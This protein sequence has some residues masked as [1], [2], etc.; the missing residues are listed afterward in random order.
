MEKPQLVVLRWSGFSFVAKETR[1]LIYGDETRIFALIEEV[2]PPF[3]LNFFVMRILPSKSIWRTGLI[4]L[5]QLP[6]VINLT[7]V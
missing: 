7:V 1:A 2:F 6:F 3:P 5:A 4:T